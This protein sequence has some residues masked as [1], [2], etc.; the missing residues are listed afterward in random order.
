MIFTHSEIDR[1]KTWP[2]VLAII[3]SSILAIPFGMLFSWTSPFMVKITKDKINYNITEGEASVFTFIPPILMISM[4]PV[5]SIL[6]DIIGRKRT[7]ILIALPQIIAWLLTIASNNVW[8]LYLS[9]VFSGIGDGGILSALPMYVGEIAVP[10]IRGTWGNIINVFIYFGIFLINVIGAY[11]DVKQTA[12]I[13]IGLP[14]FYIAIMCFMPE[15]PYYF[16]KK[17]DEENA[18][19]S[20]RWL[21]GKTDVD[22]IYKKLK[23]DIERQMSEAGTWKDLVAVKSNQRALAAGIF[24]RVSQQL[25]GSAAFNVYTKFIFEK[26]GTNIS[27]SVASMIYTGLCFS[28]LFVT[29][30]IIE[31]FG[32]K[33]S[34]MG[35]LSTCGIVLLSQAIYQF[36]DQH[37]PSIDVSSIKWFPVAGMI[38]YVFFCSFG[39]LNI[40]T[41]MSGELFS[42]SIKAKGMSVLTI[43]FGVMIFV[44]N[45]I[46]Y[47]LNTHVG[48][49]CPF[50]FFGICNIISTFLCIYIIPETKGRTLEEIQQ[51]LRSGKPS[52]RSNK[53]SA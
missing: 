17:N 46:F 39:I 44:A 23:S 13:S 47:L 33:K 52:K 15:S 29:G 6:C 14:I 4:S 37:V 31:Q 18:K 24:L 7:L 19:K 35:A 40:P 16:V 49:Y 42:T 45:N 30:F 21:R 28:L 2:Q 51:E 12:Y 32:R 25:G 27:S 26:S 36:I 10:K 43:T 53:N 5:F 20:L 22:E 9:R 8:V 38:L 41:L 1:E 3:V 48:L 50:L 11:C 34:Y